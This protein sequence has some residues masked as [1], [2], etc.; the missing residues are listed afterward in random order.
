ML[1]KHMVNFILFLNL[2]KKSF[3]LNIFSNLSSCYSFN[4]IGRKIWIDSLITH[5]YDDSFSSS[6]PGI[7]LNVIKPEVPGSCI[8]FISISAT[9]E[10]EVNLI[11]LL[12]NPYI[13]FKLRYLKRTFVIYKIPY[14][15]DHELYI[16]H[17]SVKLSHYHI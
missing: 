11:E 9:A 1:Y 8:R 2:F 6:V 16:L 15:H 12:S 3:C 10:L 7:K 17:L 4:C 13:R 14:S 5:C